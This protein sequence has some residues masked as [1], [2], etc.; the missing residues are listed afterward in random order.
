MEYPRLFTSPRTISP[1]LTVVCALCSGLHVVLP[2]VLFLVQYPHGNPV[3][4]HGVTTVVIG[5]CGAS[6]SPVPDGA[7]PVPSTPEEFGEVLKS[8]IARWDRVI[9]EH[10][11][12]PE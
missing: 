11:I 1:S 4:N 12:K 6:C 2:D 3:V 8:E 9:R 10:G 7:E 5:D